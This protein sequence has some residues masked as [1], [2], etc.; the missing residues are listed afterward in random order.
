M[1]IAWRLEP[2]TALGI[3]RRMK[4]A[5]K[6]NWSFGRRERIDLITAGLILYMTFLKNGECA[7]SRKLYSSKVQSR[8]TSFLSR[9][10]GH[11]LKIEIKEKEP[12]AKPTEEG[13]GEQMKG[14]PVALRRGNWSLWSKR[15]ERNEVQWNEAREV[16]EP[17][18]VERRWK[19]KEG[20]DFRKK[21]WA[22]YAVCTRAWRTSASSVAG[23][24]E[25]T[26]RRFLKNDDRLDTRV[27][28]STGSMPEK[29]TLLT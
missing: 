27:C 8:D 9:S 21:P 1:N 26:E 19:P 28:I 20:A 13:L 25:A 3:W 12:S 5:C 11:Y 23:L 7:K 4:R 16:R 22:T 14:S 29:G 2:G 18:R 15:N 24:K 17:P 6:M 10:R